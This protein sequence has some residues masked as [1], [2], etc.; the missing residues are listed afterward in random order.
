MAASLLLRNGTVLLHDEND[1]V[2][3]T[4]TDVLVQGNLIKS[5]GTDLPSSGVEIIDCTNKIVS[6]GFVDT[7]HH[8]WQSQ[9]RGRHADETLIQYLPTGNFT[10]SL[11]TAQD[12]AWG[13]LGGCLEMLN[14]GT[15]T[16]IDFAHL[17]YSPDNN[18]AAIAATVSSGIRS[19]YGYCPNPRLASWEP[20]T[21]NP[22]GLAGHA[23]PTLYELAKASPWANGRVTLGFAFDGWPY[24]PA[25]YLDKLMSQ[26][27]DL[28]VSVLQFHYTP[29]MFPGSTNIPQFLEDKN[30]LDSRWLVA[31]ANDM[32]TE[33]VDLFRKRG[34]H[35]STTPSTELQMG[36][37]L[38]VPAFRDDY[39]C[40]VDICSLGVDCHSAA[41]A[42]LPGE[43][44][45]ALQSAR[46]AR[47][48]RFTAQSKVALSVKYTVEEAFNQ[49]TIRGARAAKMGNRIGSIAEGNL[50]DL[51]IFNTE[52]PSMVC[53]AA[54]DPVA[55]IILH[56]SPADIDCVI[57][58]G[59]VRK[60]CGR[61]VSVHVSPE[62]AKW[63]GDNTELTWKEVS[64]QLLSS[65]A[66]LQKKVD[67][68]HMKK[69]EKG[70]MEAF[71]LNDANYADV[72]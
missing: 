68:L 14:C 47:H 57:V 62:D 12:M 1:H 34:V 70:V 64:K 35:L 4:V 53:A 16:V 45:L 59:I 20:F 10:S 63:F 33:N 26:L 15:T 28:N 17:N 41:C 36:M 51:V 67:G 40:P 42:Y 44:R 32:P 7:H 71:H 29:S 66:A 50:A 65:R 11:Y 61:L 22:N 56:S 21:V 43:A 19:N 72:V 39:G 31:H 48:N 58:D 2:K 18:W 6:P 38:P 60:E 25:E 13:Q 30:Y 27:R 23:M 8:V 37:G 3:P 46:A 54:H 49:A 55:A 9:L 69:A 5:I 24:L 52:T